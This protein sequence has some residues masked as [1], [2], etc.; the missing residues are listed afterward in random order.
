MRLAG[1]RILLGVTGSIS[2]YKSAELC[3]LLVKEGAEVRV[4]MSPGAL[5]FITPLTLSTLSGNA[6]ETHMISD[7]NTWNNHVELGLWAQLF[8][9]AP[10]SAN[11]ISSMANGTCTNLL[12]AVF[13]S[14][15][16]PVMVAPA[17]D[18]DM[19]LHPSTTANLALLHKRK[20][21]QLGPE[22]G[23]LA[24]GLIGEG[25]LMEP[26]N[27][28]EEVVSYFGI[29]PLPL[30]GKKVLITA[31]PTREA[32]D[33]VRYISNHSSGKT[34]VAVAV[35]FAEAGAEV[36]LVSGPLQIDI[37]LYI[38]NYPVTTAI[39][40]QEECERLFP[41]CDYAVMT[42]A[43]ADFR[44]ASPAEQKIKKDKAEL[45]LTLFPNPDILAG[46]GAMKRKD[47]FVVGFALE[48][49]NAMENARR[50]L[51]TKNLDLIVLNIPDKTGSGFGHDTNKVT[52]ISS[53]GETEET[54]LM[55]K[56]AIARM[57]VLK[58]IDSLHA[59]A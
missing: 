19:Y 47:Q 35:A 48:T 22:K 27:I 36:H 40:M 51:Q 55:S 43:V 1:K 54:P 44:P 10:A 58:M 45:S 20:V 18:H 53:G 56:N 14:A 50:K 52:F 12:H 28:I 21:M 49:E 57:L 3:R 26:V 37:P 30:E 23:A 6:V 31:G 2:A 13:L 34:G 59:K 38:N 33:P 11:T 5:D 17:M 7:V 25:R 41:T 9:I 46:I 4:I 32:I 8:L 39:E 29:T 15:R 24:S 42:A 16:C